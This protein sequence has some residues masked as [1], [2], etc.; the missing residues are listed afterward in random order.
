MTWVYLWFESESSSA[1]CPAGQLGLYLNEAPTSALAAYHPG[2]P[3]VKYWNPDPTLGLLKS[4][5][6]TRLLEL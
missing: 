5:L 3:P 2:I 6:T 1:T 4:P